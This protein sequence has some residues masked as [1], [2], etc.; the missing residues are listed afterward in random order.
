M[1]IKRI[2]KLMK[3]ITIQEKKKTGQMTIKLKIVI[4]KNI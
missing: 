4:L 2:R 1:K 3:I